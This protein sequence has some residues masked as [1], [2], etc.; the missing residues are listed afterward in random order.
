MG[1]PAS[2]PA[3]VTHAVELRRLPFQPGFGICKLPQR[4]GKLARG[5]AL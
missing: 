3:R 2:M 1:R 4:P 5:A